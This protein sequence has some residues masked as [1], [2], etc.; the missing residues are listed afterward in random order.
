MSLIPE[1]RD[2]VDRST[3]SSWVRC[4]LQVNPLRYAQRHG[5]D[6]GLRDQSTYD[7]A[8]AQA[9]ADSGVG[10]VAVTDHFRINDSES[11]LAA[12]QAAGLVALPGFEANTSEGVHLL[13]V[14]KENTPLE[15][16][17]H[18]IRA[19]DLH[20]PEAD[21]PISRLSATQLMVTMNN[22]GATCIAA[23]ATM[24]SGVLKTLT[25]SARIQ[26]WTSPHLAGAAIP[27][28]VADAPESVRLI[29][30]NQDDAHRRD[31]SL[32]V[33]NAGD[34]S[35]P[36]D[37]AK[38]GTTVLLRMTEPCWRGLSHALADPE[39]R[40]RLNSDP[41][42]LLRP[43]IRAVHWDGGY[44]DGQTVV[45]S[46]HLNV[47]VGA[48]GAGKS[49]VLE[50]IR[51]AFGLRAH[52]ER[53]DAGFRD[54]TQAALANATISVI[55]EHPSPR[56]SR[57]V[58]R[59]TFPH[60]PEVLDWDT[61][62]PSGRRVEDLRPLPEVYGQH[63]IAELSQDE[64]KRTQV[65]RR[66]VP[67]DGALDEKVATLGSKLADV[68]ARLEV[69]EETVDD[70]AAQAQLLAGVEVELKKWKDA[71]FAAKLE[72]GT[73]VER[74]H[75]YLKRVEEFVSQL[76][77][78]LAA[79]ES[80]LADV[81][82]LPTELAGAPFEAELLLARGQADVARDA[83]SK[84]LKAAKDAVDQRTVALVDIRARYRVRRTNVER[85]LTEVRKTLGPNVSSAEFSELQRRGDTAREAEQ[86]LPRAKREMA[87]LE[88]E[89]RSV[90]LEREEATAEQTRKL[91]RASNKVNA[92]L[93]R[94]RVN[95]TSAPDLVGFRAF[96]GEHLKGFRSQSHQVL[97]ESPN[98]SFRGL[99]Q[100]CREG[101]VAVQTMVALAPSDL[102]RLATLEP[103]A[104]RALEALR[105][106]FTMT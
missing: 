88:S 69:A 58:V 29:L 72:Q 34:V 28:P 38:S 56:P 71:G 65:L 86:T 100:A 46:E 14:F 66:F 24:D 77:A 103:R 75:R 13:I 102:R 39:S 5:V 26:A 101:E 27:G 19:C 32:A 12:L 42:P 11:L 6:T 106:S 59:R 1:W 74:E 37:A 79:V 33:I 21:S 52:G 36:E 85:T 91:E 67:A 96:A 22:L 105:R 47:L 10:L 64:T 57:V 4:A 2:H 95:V 31:H 92:Q 83:A 70:L 18:A 35:R 30:H 53:A 73:V 63:E 8:V 15:D 44:L 25:G 61:F 84:I 104:L 68:E 41:E 98:L 50:S 97:A 60:P 23:H 48:P 43:V 55:V 78:Q 40:V 89:R 87:D 93:K 3:A 81:P 90:L 45:L 17:R 80:A 99:A 94:V 7:A 54:L 82:E 62:E 20:D 51:A 9:L 49:T 16:I 76:S